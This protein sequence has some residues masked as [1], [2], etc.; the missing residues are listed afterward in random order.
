MERLELKN[1]V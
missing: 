1:D